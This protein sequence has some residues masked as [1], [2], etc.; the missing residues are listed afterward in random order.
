MSIFLCMTLVNVDS[1]EH[2]SLAPGLLSKS[3]M[4]KRD[5]TEKQSSKENKIL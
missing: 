4:K 3:K 1:D 2:L 5:Q